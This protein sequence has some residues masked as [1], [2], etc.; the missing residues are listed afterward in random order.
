MRYT[1]QISGSPVAP[2]LEHAF[3]RCGPEHSEAKRYVERLVPILAN[4]NLYRFMLWDESGKMIATWQADLE[5]RARLV[6]ERA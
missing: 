6:E 4:R 1:L 2:L 5:P 3:E